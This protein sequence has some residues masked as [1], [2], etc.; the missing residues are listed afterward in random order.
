MVKKAQLSN[1]SP[2]RGAATGSAKVTAYRRSAFTIPVL[3][4]CVY[5]HCV[6]R[7]RE[8]HWKLQG[9]NDSNGY[10]LVNQ[11]DKEQI[12]HEI[13]ANEIVGAVLSPLSSFEPSLSSPSTAKPFVVDGM[14]VIFSD[15]K[16]IQEF[17]SDVASISISPRNEV[18]RLA[19]FT[20][21]NYTPA[22]Y[23]PSIAL[24]NQLLQRPGANSSLSNLT[25]QV[26]TSPLEGCAVGS[27]RKTA[28]S[29]AS[30]SGGSSLL[31]AKG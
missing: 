10:I 16:S 14:P 4:F 5:S 20:R 30:Q 18:N 19:S 26:T 25:D 31:L 3:A 28:L 23:G 29:S 24:T 13:V 17:L 11:G 21:T 27:S 9:Y 2:L 8:V 22:G 12:P 7:F 1:L 15:L 6:W